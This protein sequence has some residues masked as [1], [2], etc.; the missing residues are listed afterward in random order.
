M[1]EEVKLADW[2]RVFLVAS[3]IVAASQGVGTAQALL[4]TLKLYELFDKEPV[5][6]DEPP[7]KGSE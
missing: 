3:S 1:Q 2:D 7:L 6:D 5:E 4:I